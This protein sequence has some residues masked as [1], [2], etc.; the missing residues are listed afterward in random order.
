MCLNY[1]KMGILRH[2]SAIIGK[3]HGEYCHNKRPIISIKQHQRKTKEEKK[4]F[5]A[6]QRRN[7]MKKGFKKV[8]CQTVR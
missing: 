3:R 4:T 2:A 5:V 7:E 1:C 8:Y 6:F